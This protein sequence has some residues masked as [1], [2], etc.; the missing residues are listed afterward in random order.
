M[1]IRDL[2]K[3]Q[4]TASAEVHQTVLEVA[5][6]MQLIIILLRRVFIKPTQED[7]ISIMDIHEAA[8]H[9]LVKPIRL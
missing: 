5:E 7:L 1:F 6:M 8:I 2:L 9:G 4:D 3:N